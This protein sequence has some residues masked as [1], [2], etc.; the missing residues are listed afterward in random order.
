MSSQTLDLV[1]VE[2]ATVLA[3]AAIWVG[4][5]AAPT[6]GDAADGVVLAVR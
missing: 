5:E 2:A 6:S 3:D 1:E 4:V